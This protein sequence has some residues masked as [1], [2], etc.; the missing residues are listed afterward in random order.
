[1]VGRALG[2]H[3]GVTALHPHGFL[4]LSEAGGGV[5]GVGVGQSSLSALVTTRG[6]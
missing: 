1:M 2:R 4:L 3:F 6:C 5:S